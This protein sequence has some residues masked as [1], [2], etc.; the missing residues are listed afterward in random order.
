MS[1]SPELLE[2]VREIYENE[3][4]IG[5]LENDT[6]IVW[7]NPDPAPDLE[8]GLEPL[9]LDGLSTN[10]FGL[11]SARVCI[12]WGGDSVQI[13]ALT[14]PRPDSYLFDFAEKVKDVYSRHD[15][16]IC[17]DAAAV[18]LAGRQKRTALF[19]HRDHINGNVIVNA[20]HR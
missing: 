20:S 7:R 11:V 10:S 3:R 12:G 13:D 16:L 1:N 17:L 2:V 18:L 8:L 19:A 15:H 14:R 9:V 4:G 6:H 5:F